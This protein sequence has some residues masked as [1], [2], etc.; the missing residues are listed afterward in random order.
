MNYIKRRSIYYIAIYFLVFVPVF[1][2]AQ[3]RGQSRIDSLLKVLP[4]LNEEKIKLYVL[5]N[6]STEYTCINPDEGIK[7]GLKSLDLAE[8]LHAQKDIGQAYNSIGVNYEAKA[9][10]PKALEYSFKALKC[11][12][13]IKDLPN[14]EIA[15]VLSNIGNIYLNQASYDKA[16]EYYLKSLPIYE[17][18]GKNIGLA[19][20]LN[21]VGSVYAFQKN[22]D[23]SNDFYTSKRRNWQ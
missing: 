22:Y 12:E 14:I 1:G 15:R 19:N 6:L 20:A 5:Y 3:L 11:Y 21:G 10:H 18:S 8:H 23:K 17:K 7:F 9:E 16:L 4:G 2:F 13:D